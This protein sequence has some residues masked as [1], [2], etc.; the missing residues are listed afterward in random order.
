MTTRSYGEDLGLFFAVDPSFGYH[1]FFVMFVG[2]KSICDQNYYH[3]MLTQKKP[4]NKLMSWMK[5][6][7]YLSLIFT[8]VILASCSTTDE[9]PLQHGADAT[10][11]SFINDLV[12]QMTLKEKIGQMSQATGSWEVTGPVIKDANVIEMASTGKVGSFLNIYGAERT[13][14]AQELAV[15]NSRLGIPLIFGYDMIH[16][17]ATTFPIPL[18]EAA[19][20]DLELIRRSAE[21]TALEATAAGLHWN[22][23]PMVDIARD[24]RW[25]RIMEGA[26]EDPWW[27]SQVAVARIQGYQGNDLSSASTVAAT[28]KHFAG[29]GAAEGGRDYNTTEISERTMREVYLP[30][31]KAAVDAGA[32]T[33]MNGFNDINGIPATAS[34]FLV[35]QILKDEWGFKGYVVSDWASVQEMTDHSFA[36]SDKEAAQRAFLA[37]CDME[38]VSTTYTEYLEE[39]VDEFPEYEDLIDDAVKRVLGIKYDL[40]LFEDPYRYSDPEREADLVL[41]NDHFR[42]AYEVAKSSIVLLENRNNT[43]PLD[44]DLKRIAVIGP[45]ADDAQTPLGTWQA[46]GKPENVTTLL[47]GIKLAVDRETRVYSAS[48]CEVNSQDRSGFKQ[49]RSLAKQADVI[50][51]VLGEEAMMSGEALSRSELG[52][53][54][55]QLELLKMLKETG[56]P[57]VVVLMNGRPIAEPWMYANCD[58]VLNAWHLGVQSGPAIADVLFGE[59]NPSGKLPVTIPRSVGQIPLYYNHKNTGR[60]F[61]PNDR[62]TTKY[63]DEEHGPQY[64]FGYGLSY[65][66]FDYGKVVLDRTTLSPDHQ[67]TAE[68]TVTNSGKFAGE[69][70]VQLYIRDLFGSVTR[71]VLELKGAQKI[72][73]DPGESRTV[74]FSLTVD[75][76][77]FWD[78]D[79]VFNWEPGDFK[80]FIGPNSQDLMSADFQV[81]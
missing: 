13:R 42:H 69:E 63:I 10:K 18:A 79:M 50:I 19:S 72:K 49:A 24:P 68:V 23:A 16:G 73:L 60:A 62:Y 4:G 70:V 26:G 35:R 3:V 11:Q 45:L 31:F 6:M 34:E 52:L 37:G 71:P 59:Y 40:G 17:Y 22:F 14:N 41:H 61:D 29:Y 12:S 56:K 76:L 75:D 27:G 80:L 39:L 38:M 7:R 58:A 25:G 51:A 2:N 66:Q 15:N 64:P 53:P 55:V 1:R 20:W 21:I 78:K 81:H 46:Q 30:P 5:N 54:G 9:T 44:P 65:T 77:R 57:V 8:L 32:A 43:L 36:A 74:S 28:A 47:E 33:L 48:G 67:L